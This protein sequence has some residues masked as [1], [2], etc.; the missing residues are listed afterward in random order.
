MG[1]SG[2]KDLLPS[3]SVLII[4]GTNRKGGRLDLTL[5]HTADH[6]ASALKVGMQRALEKRLINII[7][8]EERFLSSPRTAIAASHLARNSLTFIW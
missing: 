8:I 4:P 2:L 3:K 7:Q 6:R 1:E 5:L